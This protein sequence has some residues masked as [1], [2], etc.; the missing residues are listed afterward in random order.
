MYIYQT[1]GVGART[2]RISRK[3][4]VATSN[5]CFLQQ[6]NGHAAP[7]DICARPRIVSDIYGLHRT[8]YP[9]PRCPPRS[10]WLCRTHPSP[11]ICTTLRTSSPRQ[12]QRRKRWTRKTT[13]RKEERRYVLTTQSPYLNTIATKERRNTLLTKTK[14]RIR[15]P[16]Q[17][18]LPPTRHLMVPR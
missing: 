5:A 8:L 15:D 9:C 7:T 13:R 16:R 17:H 2:M 14:R 12:S 4:A 10:Q 18:H 6:Q 11:L 1:C 3:V